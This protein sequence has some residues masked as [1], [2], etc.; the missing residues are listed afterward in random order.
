MSRSG[1]AGDDRRRLLLEGLESPQAVLTS[2]MLERFGKAR[3]D[4]STLGIIE[5][6]GYEAVGTDE[7]DRPVEL[8]W[9]P[10]NGRFGYFSESAGWVS[11]NHSAIASFAISID[12]AISVITRDF[13]FAGRSCAKVVAEDRLWD[14]GYVRLGRPKPNPVLF[15]RRLFEPATK[16]VVERFLRSS[17]TSTRRL[18]MTSTTPDRLA[19]EFAGCLLVSL[20]D[21][22]SD[23]LTVSP[24]TMAMLLDKRPAIQPD[25]IIRLVADGKEVVFKGERYRF[26]KG[27]R[28]R[29]VI[30]ELYAR[31]RAG[32]YWVSSAE[33]AVD[34]GLGEKTR[35][36]DA[37]KDHPAWGQL[38]TERDGMCGF[39]FDEVPTTP[40]PKRK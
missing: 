1:H 28:Q 10:E 23:D 16:T 19:A 39:C 11:V 27:L 6:R 26:V 4:L 17:P 2:A 30:K 29:A 38:L 14:V 35:I 18:L 8:I 37:F 13:N 34:A 3:A 20:W 25:E 9:S 40:S 24:D 36:R 15:S 33:V 5:A 22:L 32:E 21:V 12:H 7:H 31:Y